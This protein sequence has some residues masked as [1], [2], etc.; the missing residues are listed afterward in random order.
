MKAYKIISYNYVTFFLIIIILTVNKHFLN[1][2]NISCRI[3]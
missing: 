3:F 1:S 2:A